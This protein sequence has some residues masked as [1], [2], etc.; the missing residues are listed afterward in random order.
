MKNTVRILVLATVIFGATVYSCTKEALINEAEIPALKKAAT[1]FLTPVELLGKHIFF[2][3]IS[4]PGSMSCAECHAP[5]VGFTG[6]VGGINLKGS[7]YMGA[8]PQRF[9]NRKPPSAAYATQSPVLYF[10]E[11]DGLFIGGNFWDGRAT[12]E[13]LG[14][15]AADQAMGPFLNPVEQNMPSKEAVLKQIASSKYVGLWEEVWESPL[16]YETEED[17]EQNY[18]RVALA[19]AA[20][21]GSAE[22]CSFTSK[23]DY[24]L[25]GMAKLTEQ[26][27]WGLELF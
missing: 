16:T 14:N 27:R 9:G 13:V 24:Y 20:Y 26:E 22:V 19:I 18:G 25:K 17:I 2:D 10:D 15:P 12:G 7:V 8:V 3:K 4:S 5:S 11:E 6:P 21:E 1:V 23:Y